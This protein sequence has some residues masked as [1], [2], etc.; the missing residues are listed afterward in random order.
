MSTPFWVGEAAAD[1]WE[2]AGGEEPPP[3]D[4]RGPI[5]YALPLAVVLLPRLR[6]AGIDAWLRRQSVPCGVTVRD[7]PLRACLVA[8]YGQGFVFVDGT[9]PDDEQR[10]SLAH[11]VAHFLRD[12]W[13][14]RAVIVE[15]LGPE[16][17]AVLDGERPPRPVERTHA[18][19]ANVPLGY[20]VHYMERTAD[21]HASTTI[22][23]AEH[24]ADLLAFELLAPADAVLA[25]AG[26]AP[27]GEQRAAVTRLLHDS[28]GLPTAPAAAYAALLAPEPPRADPFLRR[29]GLVP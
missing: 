29:L 11:E 8:R 2:R 26:T 27:A 6:A 17:F 19:L 3:R 23:R 24:D 18:L 4:L 7:R 16:I 21:G 15:R 22:D 25:A 13:Q 14:P 9:D 1:F 28:Y 5:A 12:Y 10:F 20:H